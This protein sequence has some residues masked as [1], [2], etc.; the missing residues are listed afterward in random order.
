MFSLDSHLQPLQNT[1]QKYSSKS[2]KI[3]YYAV[4]FPSKVKQYFIYTHFGLRLT[5]LL[6]HII[7]LNPRLGV[8]TNLKWFNNTAD[9]GLH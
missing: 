1:L 2:K 8:G 5:T 6:A 3:F 7:P 9:L 4:S